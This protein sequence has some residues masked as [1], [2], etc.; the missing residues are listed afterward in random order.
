[1]PP[2]LYDLH[3]FNT[4]LLDI[5]FLQK[6]ITY[7]KVT[8]NKKPYELIVQ[9]IHS[10]LERYLLNE[11]Y[12]KVITCKILFNNTFTNFLMNLTSS[13]KLNDGFSNVLQWLDFSAINAIS[14]SKTIEMEL[15]VKWINQD[16]KSYLKNFNF[17]IYS[18]NV[19][20]YLNHYTQDFSLNTSLNVLV[21]NL[22]QSINIYEA[23]VNLSKYLLKSIKDLEYFTLLQMRNEARAVAIEK[24]NYAT[25]L[26]NEIFEDPV[27][28]IIPEFCA[29]EYNT[30]TEHDMYVFYKLINFRKR[31]LYNRKSLAQESLSNNS[32]LP[33]RTKSIRDDLQVYYKWIKQKNRFLRVKKK[34]YRYEEVSDEC[35]MMYLEKYKNVEK[36]SLEALSAR[37]K[38]KQLSRLCMTFKHKKVTLWRKIL[39]TQYSFEDRMLDMRSPID[40]AYDRLN[41][42]LQNVLLK[43]RPYIMLNN[44]SPLKEPKKPLPMVLVETRRAVKVVERAILIL[45]EAKNT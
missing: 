8:V 22:E 16:S 33:I 5:P 13:N 4:I 42:S 19:R 2:T 31:I 26:K 36:A 35:F 28:P 41:S 29:I 20:D 3:R 24:T 45:N 10:E 12:W 15:V 40:Y 43:L 30:M 38:A 1:M 23:N 9:Y 7:I 34:R 32:I 44:M 14:K 27:I 11:E 25:I 17:A 6:L 21:N 37:E 39:C 18:T